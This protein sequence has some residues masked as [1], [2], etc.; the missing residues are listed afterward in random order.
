MSA[1]ATIVAT[2]LRRG[3]EESS[4][5]YTII[6]GKRQKS[7]DDPESDVRQCQRRTGSSAGG[8]SPTPTNYTTQDTHPTLPDTGVDRG[9]YASGE[10]SPRGTECPSAHRATLAEA[11]V[12]AQVHADLVH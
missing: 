5:D 8:V 6:G 12:S 4:S 2:I 3:A 7:Q 9:D 11:F 10:V 1:S